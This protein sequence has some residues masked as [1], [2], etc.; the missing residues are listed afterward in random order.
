LSLKASAAANALNGWEAVLSSAWAVGWPQRPWAK[1]RIKGDKRI[2]GD[3]DFAAKVLEECRQQLEQRYHYQA[4]GYDFDWLVRQVAALSGFEPEIVTRRG[5]YPDTVQ[6]RSVLCYFAS[7][8]LGISTLE[9]AR[10]LVISQPTASQSVKRGE[11]IVKE[12]G[13]R[14]MGSIDISIP[15]NPQ[16][17]SW[18]IYLWSGPIFGLFGIGSVRNQMFK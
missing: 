16:F 17:R 4:R 9:L 1:D 14:L 6:A 13:L 18:V 7:R 12:K 2:L 3:G 15:F 11:M 8:D 10:R 5:R